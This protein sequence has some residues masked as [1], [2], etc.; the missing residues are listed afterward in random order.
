VFHLL[1]LLIFGVSPDS[2]R[3]SAV[4]KRPP[5]QT[6]SASE[7]LASHSRVGDAMPSLER[8]VDENGAEDDPDGY[9]R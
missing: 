3:S 4:L 1:F 2:S 7:P 9:D 8:E 6:K 5:L